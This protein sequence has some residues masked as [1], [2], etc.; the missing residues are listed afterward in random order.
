MIFGSWFKHHLLFSFLPFEMLAIFQRPVSKMRD[1][2]PRSC[3]PKIR[4]CIQKLS[5]GLE[6]SFQC[7]LFTSPSGVPRAPKLPLSVKA[8]HSNCDLLF[9]PGEKGVG[10]TGRSA[11]SRRGKIIGSWHEKF[12][13]LKENSNTIRVFANFTR[14]ERN[15]WNSNLASLQEID[16]S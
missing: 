9:L 16:E 6:S 12:R 13:Q 2:K 7:R 15:I 4:I 14:I 8:I 10:I 5:G 11:N 1:L 3:L